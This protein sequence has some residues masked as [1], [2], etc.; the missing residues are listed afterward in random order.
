MPAFA[1]FAPVSIQRG[2][3][4]MAGQSSQPVA[5]DKFPG[6]T[7]EV[8]FQS[9]ATTLIS[10]DGNG[11]SDIFIKTGDPVDPHI[12]VSQNLSLLGNGDS[13][14]PDATP[15]GLLVVF[16]TLATNLLVNDSN[17]VADIALRDLG[18]PGSPPERISV[19]SD[20]TPADGPSSR[21]AISANGRVIAF[22]SDA[23]NLV[24]FDTNGG[25]DV[26]VRD[27]D[28][29]TTTRV[30]VRSDGTQAANN[31]TG[32][33]VD[34][35]GDGRFVVFSSI[36]DLVPGDTNGVSDV[37]VRDR[38][39]GTTTRISLNT[40][41]GD[42]NGPSNNP[43]IS[44]DGRF[45]A[46][47]SAATDLV[48]S[49][50]NSASDVFVRVLPGSRTELVSVNSAGAQGNGASAEPSISADGRF[51]AFASTATNLGESA[52]SN[53]LK[54]VFLRD[55]MSG[56]TRSRVQGDGDSGEPSVSGDGR[57]FAFTT[58]ATNLG[59]SDGNVTGDVWR[60]LG[61]PDVSG[62]ITAVTPPVPRAAGRFSVSLNAAP[63]NGIGPQP[64]GALE[65]RVL[66]GGSTIARCLTRALD[67]SGNGSCELSVDRAGT[68][69]VEL[70]FLGDTQFAATPRLATG[71]LTVGPA[72][73]STLSIA[74]QAPDP[75]LANRSVYVQAELRPRGGRPEGLITFTSPVGNCIAE[76][77]NSGCLLPFGAV[78][79]PINASYSG[80]ST[81]SAAV[82]APADQRIG[83]SIWQRLLESNQGSGRSPGGPAG[84][85]PGAL[86]ADGRWFVFSTEQPY[87]VADDRDDHEDVFLLDQRLGLIRRISQAPDGSPGNSDS[88]QPAIS[89]DGRWVAFTTYANNLLP[90]DTNDRGDVVIVD[91]QNDSPAELVSVNSSGGFANDTAFQPQLSHDGSLVAFHS[92]ASDLIVGDSNSRI[93]VFVRDRREASTTRV[94]VSSGGGEGSG[95][96]AGAVTLDLSPDGRFVLFHADYN[97][98]VSGDNN[99]QTDLFRH[100][101]YT[102]QTLRANIATDGT[103]SANSTREGS[104]S[105]DGDRVVFST[106]GSLVSEDSN[107]LDD[108]YL[109]EF[110][111]RSTRLVSVGAYGVIG[112]GSGSR[113]PVITNQGDVY[114]LSDANEFGTGG[115]IQV[116]QANE[117]GSF[118]ELVTRDPD[119][120][121][122]NANSRSL[123]VARDG[124]WVSFA[125]EASNLDPNAPLGG[126]MLA[127]DKG[128]AR[129]VQRAPVGRQPNGPSFGATLSAD[130]RHAVLI[131]AGN[132][133]GPEDKNDF[134]DIYWLDLDSGVIRL[135]SRDPQQADGAN[136]PSFGRTGISA[137]GERVA[138]TS[139][140]SNL[141]PGDS[142]AARDVFLADVAGGTLTRVSV[143]TTGDQAQ[144]D[145]ELVSLSAD[146]T[147]VLFL[148]TDDLDPPR[149][150]PIG[151]PQQLYLRSVVGA[152]TELLSVNTAGAGPINADVIAADGPDDSGCRVI[153]ISNAT[154]V[155]SGVTDGLHHLY[156]RNRC[157]NTTTVIDAVG[158]TLG[159][160]DVREA[161]LAGGGRYVA[162][163]S[164]ATNLVEGVTS[165]PQVYLRD[166]QNGTLRLVS[167]DT[168]GVPIGNALSSGLS[169]DDSGRYV[170]FTIASG[171]SLE[172]GFGS[173]E[174]LIRDNLAGETAQ[175]SETLRFSGSPALSGDGRRLAFT[176]NDDSLAV[177]DRNATDDVLIRDNPLLGAV[178][179]VTDIGVDEGDTSVTEVNIDVT[180]SGGSD[181]PISVDVL[182][183]NGSATAPGDYQSYNAPLI[184]SSDGT[185]TITVNVVG[186]TV[187]EPDESFTIRVQTQGGSPVTLATGTVSILNDDVAPNVCTRAGAGT[188]VDVARW[189]CVPTS[190]V[191]P[192]AGDTAIFDSADDAATLSAS[193]EVA[194]LDLR[195]GLIDGAGALTVTSQF[196]WSGGT[197]DAPDTF[198]P[199]TLP[200]GS[201]AT[202]NG[203]A[204]TLRRRQLLNQGT[205]TWTAGTLTL[206]G[207]NT[208]LR[209]DAQFVVDV[210]S[211]TLR[212]A[213]DGASGQFFHHTFGSDRNVIKRGAGRYEMDDRI[214]FRNGN[215]VLVEAGTASFTGPGTSDPGP[216]QIDNGGILEFNLRSGQQ[217]DIAGPVSGG[218]SL[219]KVGQGDL[220]LQGP[221]GAEGA[222]VS[223]GRLLFFQ[224]GLVNLTHLLVTGNGTLGGPANLQA[225]RLNW[226]GGTISGAASS[227]LRLLGTSINASS[228]LGT[229]KCLDARRLIF[230]GEAAW[231]AGK[232][233]L[234][235]S[236]VIE[237]A[238]GGSLVANFGATEGLEN[239]DASAVRLDVAGT[240]R[241]QGSAVLDSD[242]STSVIGVL[243]INGGALTQRANLSGTGSAIIAAG[244]RLQFAPTGTLNALLPL[245]GNG[246]VVT[247]SGTTQLQR[248][249]TGNT[250]N[251]LVQG[252]S[253]A[254]V[255][256]ALALRSLGV[257]GGVLQLFQSVSAAGASSY[258][259]GTIQIFA[260]NL[261]LAGPTAINVAST[262]RLI[263]CESGCS[264][265]ALRLRAGAD[266]LISG[267]ASARLTGSLPLILDDPAARLAIGTGATLE[268]SGADQLQRGTLVVDGIL[269]RATGTLGVGNGTALALSGNGTLRAA[270]G[271]TLNATIAPG[272]SGIGQLTLD[273]PTSITGGQLQMGLASAASFDRI[274]MAGSSTL[275]L[276]P[277]AELQPG[278]PYT[279]AAG[280]VF[281]LIQHAN[282]A[283]T[284]SL[285]LIGGA[286]GFL[287]QY[288]ATAVEYRELAGPRVCRLNV[289][290][291][292]WDDPASWVC[293]P[294]DG[295][296]GAIDTAIVDNGGSV[297]QNGSRT[298]TGLQLVNGTISSTADPLIVTGSFSWTG[299]R[300]TGTSSTS[301]F[302]RIESTATSVTLGGVQKVL[303]ERE[304]RL[305]ADATWTTG[306]IELGT[307]G[308]LVIFPSRTLTTTPD[309]TPPEFVFG[310][311]VGA[312][313]NNQGRILK[314]GGGK[315]GI[316]SSVVYEGAGTLE[317]AASSGEFFLHAPSSFIAGEMRAA[318]GGRLVFANGDQNFTNTARLVGAGE[319]HFGRNTAPVQTDGA[320]SLHRVPA[321][322][323]TLSAGAQVV[324]FDATLRID[325]PGT[326]AF[327]RLTLAHPLGALVGDT[328]L[329][330][331]QALTWSAGTISTSVQDVSLV[332]ASSATA[333]LPGNGLRNLTRTLDVA[334]TMVLEG[335]SLML[336]GFNE[337]RIR[338]GAL[339][340]LSGNGTSTL[341]AGGGYASFPLQNDGRIERQGSGTTLMS[342]GLQQNGEVVIDAGATLEVGDFNTG[343][344]AR[345][346]VNGTLR[347]PSL[348][349]FGGGSVEG[350]GTL[351][352]SLVDNLAAN[353]QPG[354]AAAG[355][356]TVNGEYRQQS[357][358]RLSLDLLG[359]GCA[360]ADR[361]VATGPAMLAGGLTLNPAGGCTPVAPQEFL[362]LDATTLTGTFAAVSGVPTNYTLEYLGSSGE[363]RLKPNLLSSLITITTVTPQPTPVGQP[364]T[365][366]VTVGPV[367]PGSGPIATGTVTIT[368]AAP[369]ANE[370]CTLTLPATSCTMPLAALPGIRQL[371]ASYSGDTAYLPG[372]TSTTHPVRATPTI[373]ALGQ[374]PARTVVGEPFSVRARVSNPLSTLTPSGIV[375]VRPLPLGEPVDCTLVQ[376]TPGEA[377]ATCT[378]VISPIAA[379]KL[380]DIRYLGAEDQ[381]FGTATT[382]AVQEVDPANTTLSFVSMPNPSAPG[383][384]VQVDFTLA[385]A[386]PSQSLLSA[387]SGLLSVSDGVSS[388]TA[389]LPATRC[390]LTLTTLGTRQLR[391]RYQGDANFNPS[392]EVV[393]EHLVVDGGAELLIRKRNLL[394]TLPGGSETVYVVEVEN[395]GPLAVTAL[396]RDPVPT[397]LSNFRWTCTGQGGAVCPASGNG[398]LN[399]NVV[400]PANSLARFVLSADVQRDPEVL[401]VQEARIDPPTGVV[402]PNPANNVARDIDPIGLYGDGFEENDAE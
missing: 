195:D 24:P 57:N 90:G 350:T 188:W 54:D 78:D 266:V 240:L 3:P 210:A 231:T 82:A 263:S 170:A 398:A 91:V 271:I 164:D 383:A 325:P 221:Y 105:A 322:A 16:T 324:I 175:A 359:T 385:A 361:L 117:A 358:A 269:S 72:A 340:R 160:D 11:V 17:G 307:N 382:S 42:P 302:V 299:G 1:Q 61:R 51:I 118:L 36:A 402:D 201:T 119:G 124:S 86:S 190:G 139:D 400:M 317:V 157:T 375:R 23:G 332:V 25:T 101:R 233:C 234:R 339:L 47:E 337:I 100:D 184:F 187:P 64:R 377:E 48:L 161:V 371:S 151:S 330:V 283:R 140:A 288:A 138:F 268:L 265:G 351:Q 295:F 244:A 75:S 331:T 93:D 392:A 13:T 169:I 365:V 376:T 395:R 191:S 174:V 242:V 18:A 386:L 321:T 243:E 69:T 394:R 389:T 401:V 49:D 314:T 356:L 185:Q 46:F 14:E 387:I 204:K 362:L 141:V 298:V 232:L 168:A 264:G 68:Y 145:S 287:L 94:S 134:E 5:L 120:L 347:H 326:V 73:P 194:A 199:I 353:F 52:D 177:G 99:G 33:R 310:S 354:G 207:A 215:S 211:G 45:V 152:T 95:G 83:T 38:L 9:T 183:I 225:Q 278:G 109:H 110:S 363:V 97:N 357:D 315:S 391:A 381:T 379:A 53:G 136:A 293:T 50:G 6:Q 238:A 258:S 341:S 208:E 154:N 253:T 367:P 368:A 143:A 196:L 2:T 70:G 262:D 249:I 251:L 296:P 294:T 312:A 308:Q 390:T 200:A 306:L 380:I 189:S 241:K 329:S 323:F 305:D 346:V 29:G 297:D 88:V 158:E 259:G 40:T 133:L 66:H 202:L 388:C 198:I 246:E 192:G 318:T 8:V 7:R 12:L 193:V 344:A 223:D 206:A 261:D 217:R 374:T 286:P 267:T 352:A 135:L 277:A 290:S 280:D 125:T 186:D 319:F 224:G 31:G 197:L 44:A 171:E 144:F 111:S 32:V 229:A 205:L 349:S 114:F 282:G 209:N 149:G 338:S 43:V 275:L 327:E 373:T 4:Q 102:G 372:S 309:T 254:Q 79:G 84:L 15:D 292:L 166:L 212:L 147:K 148:S 20:G 19:A 218:G 65:Y 27:L 163:Q 260:G 348:L 122:G 116:I 103:Q 173:G 92:R 62:S 127:P 156:L 334:G 345:F 247:L 63:G 74:V 219:L 137:N 87:L 58:N 104:L 178:Y 150:V 203:S 214:E 313:V 41:D 272:N 370:S 142:N 123:A 336:D 289:P 130:G 172:R 26:F 128:Q 159:N 250:L 55:R 222:A 112:S 96:V 276:N 227:T 126:Y 108:V 176:S 10:S 343:P 291:G 56:T 301:D 355:T 303:T 245:S 397:G 115:L 107:G 300:F 220:L 335:G 333:T 235:S 311:G 304:L 28:A 396:V 132:N 216:Y 279:P 59:T 239:N 316:E 257:S 181:F 228:L 364:Y 89:G 378:G 180:L 167:L 281:P 98:L 252:S 80:D 129:A 182:S 153:Y 76:L 121:P 22:V 37:F 320:P 146:G 77:P 35:S 113:N 270:T 366:S 21:P 274:V 256:A 360:T 393:R 328:D 60:S 30:S 399:E 71:S 85:S 230:A 179:T 384:A 342:L 237:V 131:S 273:G 285:A 284:G 255:E 67:A 248:P 34:I 39:F 81:F 369:F 236:A 165:R 162:F 226:E 106:R 155:V 213:T